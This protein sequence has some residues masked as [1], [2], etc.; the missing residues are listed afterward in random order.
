MKKTLKSIAKL[1]NEV[2]FVL[3]ICYCM[4]GPMPVYANV[5]EYG[6]HTVITWSELKELLCDSD[7]MSEWGGRSI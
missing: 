7:R 4:S 6:N 1:I 3:I 5:N 2:L